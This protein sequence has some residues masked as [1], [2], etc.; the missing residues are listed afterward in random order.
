MSL[1]RRESLVGLLAATAAGP[2]LAKAA[3]PHP[4]K[5]APSKWADAEAKAQQMIADK[6]APGLQVCV[7]R[8]GA[9]VYSKGFGLADI[10][11]AT[12]MSPASV[13]KIGSITKQFTAAAMLLLAQDGKLSLNDNLSVYLPDF[14]NA[15]KLSL[16]RML[17]HTSGLGNYTNN[18]KFLQMSRTDRSTAELLQVMVDA[19]PKLDFEPGTDWRY[20]NTAFVLLGIVVE[21]VAGKPY[22]EVMRERLFVPQGL[23]HTAVDDMSEI[24]ANRAA[25][26]DNNLKTASGFNNTSYIAMTFPGGAG[27]MRSTCEDLCAWHGALLGG[28]VLKPEMLKEMLTPAT[29]NDGSL[30]KARGAEMRYGFGIFVGPVDGRPA[31]F[32]D[33]GIQGF[34]SHLETETDDQLTLATII[35]TDGGPTPPGKSGGAAL[36]EVQKAFRAAGLKA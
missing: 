10:E 22:A 21:K 25:G 17:S 28:K 2:T 3:A 1:N 29:L 6:L 33:G 9:V 4:A 23:S 16:R 30:P 18:P 19:S 31:A 15:Q 12:P 7:R 20:S 26:Y 35:N 8:H 32:H 34:A 11:T 36:G 24:V 13:C 14:P 5:G 27:A